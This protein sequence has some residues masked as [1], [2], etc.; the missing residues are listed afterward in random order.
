M[1]LHRTDKNLGYRKG[2][3]PRLSTKRRQM[4]EKKEGFFLFSFSQLKKKCHLHIYNDAPRTKI[5]L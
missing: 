1:P 3:V 4:S 5:C 2:Q